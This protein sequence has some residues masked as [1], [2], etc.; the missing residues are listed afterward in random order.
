MHKKIK[1]AVDVSNRAQ[2]NYDLTKSISKEDLDTLIYAA[3]NSPSKQNETHYQLKVY[4]DQNKIKE[5]YQ[6]TKRFSLISTKEDKEESFK[7]NNDG[8]FWQNIDNSVH[9]SQILSNLL[10]VYINDDGLPRGGNS[11]IAQNTKNLKSE[12]VQNYNN[13][14]NYSIGISVGQ[15]ILSASLLGYKTG[16]C[17][18]FDPQALKKTINTSEEVKLLVGIGLENQNIDRRLHAITKNKDVAERF[19]NGDLN[20][21]WQFPSFTKNIKVSINDQ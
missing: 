18:A 4:T 10:F 14:K 21:P 11:L 5:I 2:R 15:L 3:S 7:E 1:R 17:S 13:Q 9:N 8:I 12:S 16:I 19:R 6:C 20:D